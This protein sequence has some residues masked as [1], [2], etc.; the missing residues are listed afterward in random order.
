MC[1]QIIPHQLLLTSEDSKDEGNLI[2]MKVAGKGNFNK[3]HWNNQKQLFSL[4]II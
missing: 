1:I 3:A 4:N 2:N